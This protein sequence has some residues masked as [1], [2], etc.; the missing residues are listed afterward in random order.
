MNDGAT[1][2][3]KSAKMSARCTQDTSQD[4][5]RLGVGFQSCSTLGHANVQIG[6]RDGVYKATFVVSARRERPNVILGADFLAAHN[7]D[8][9]LRQ[10][11]FTIGKQEIQCIPEN[12]RANHA[13]LKV[14]ELDLPFSN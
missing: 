12:I 3:P 2:V 4:T 10:T 7:C 11:L 8:L 6:I 1:F 9:S 14:F 5:P 13:K